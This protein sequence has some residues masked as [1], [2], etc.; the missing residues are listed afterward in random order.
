M[1][2]GIHL[3]P[4]PIANWSGEAH[5][6]IERRALYEARLASEYHGIRPTIGP[7]LI[8]RLRGALGGQPAQV[9]A[10]ACPA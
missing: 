9:D 5:E 2:G 1:D 10:C 3:G 7:G 4:W 6:A 8:A